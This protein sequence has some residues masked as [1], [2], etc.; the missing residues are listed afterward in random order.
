MGKRALGKAAVSHKKKRGTYADYLSKPFDTGELL[1]RVAA[2]LRE[3]AASPLAEVYSCGEISFDTAEHRV[4]AAGRD[5]ALTRTEYAILKLLIKNPSRVIAK[6][7]LLERISAEYGGGKLQ[8][9][10]SLPQY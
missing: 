3:R 2:R 8:I 4:L 1:A 10:L 9:R 6:S 5:V 7:V